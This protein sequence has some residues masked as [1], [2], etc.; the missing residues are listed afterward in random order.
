MSTEIVI[1]ALQ[2]GL[3]SLERGDRLTNLWMALAASAPALLNR[4]SRLLRGS[5]KRTDGD[6]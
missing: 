6:R 4:G 5:D 1:R 3:G 2:V